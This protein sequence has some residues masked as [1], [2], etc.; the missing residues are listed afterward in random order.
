MPLIRTGILAV[1]VFYFYSVNRVIL[2]DVAAFI[3]RVEV[4]TLDDLITYYA[5]LIFAA[6]VVFIFS[7]HFSKEYYDRSKQYP[8][9]SQYLSAL[10]ASYVFT[11]FVYSMLCGSGVRWSEYER[12]ENVA[13]SLKIF[14]FVATFSSFGVLCAHRQK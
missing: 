2:N 14:V 7:E 6:Y 4:A 1:L 12:I 10:M 3:L 5:V 8:K 11:F 9:V 13:L